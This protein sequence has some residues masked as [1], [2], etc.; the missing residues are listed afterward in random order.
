MPNAKWTKSKRPA[1]SA[2]TQLRLG[3]C[4]IALLASVIVVG[5][6]SADPKPKRESRE[7]LEPPLEFMLACNGKSM[8]VTLNEPFDVKID[9]KTV[10]MKLT[11]KPYRVLNVAGVRFKYPTH[12]AFEYDG[13][14][15]SSKQ[16]TLDGNNSIL[17][18]TISTA[19]GANEAEVLQTM[20]DTYNK[21]F[22][23]SIIDRS[24]TRIRLAGKTYRGKRLLVD[25][26]GIRMSM[27][28]FAIA[29]RNETIILVVQDIV[30]D[31]GS[32]TRETAE[33]RKLLKDSFEFVRK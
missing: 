15:P 10:S 5:N 12:M 7:H 24:D 30:N 29:H 28:V 25:S 1:G 17:M 23:D 6:L 11:Q 13:S 26:L 14:E 21:S 33:V 4:L 22:G 19:A 31:D 3:A 32:E 8:P 16:W 9:G 27:D 2:H 18:L 20:V